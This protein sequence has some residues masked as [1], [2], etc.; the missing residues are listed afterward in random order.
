MRA[1]PARVGPRRPLTS[2][3][4]PFQACGNR[5]R[6]WMSERSARLLGQLLKRAGVGKPPDERR[7]PPAWRWSRVIVPVLV[8]SQHLDLAG[9]LDV[10][11]FP[12]D[13]DL[14]RRGG[15]RPVHSPRLTGVA[16]TS[17]QGTGD[18]P[19][20]TRPCRIALGWRESGASLRQQG[21][22]QGEDEAAGV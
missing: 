22:S 2:R 21:N 9:L 10:H 13:D 8:E 14:P 19:A 11:G 20:G 7:R 12:L 3:R 1:P 5:S 18:S 17:A 6:H 15:R 16:I 4:S